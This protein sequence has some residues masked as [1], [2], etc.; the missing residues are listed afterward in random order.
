[1]TSMAHF[2]FEEEEARFN[3]LSVVGADILKIENNLLLI[4]W[5]VD[6]EKQSQ[7]FCGHF[8]H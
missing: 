2:R 5:I 3:G 6:R 4:Y 1:M 8:L 7:S